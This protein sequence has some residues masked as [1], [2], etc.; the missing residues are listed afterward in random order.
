MKPSVMS[1][2]IAMIGTLGACATAPEKNASLEQARLAVD[3]VQSN[4]QVAQNAPVELARAR[5]ALREA[6][7]VW[8]NSPQDA[9]V[10][11]LAYLAERRAAIAQEIAGIKAA[12]QAIEQASRDRDRLL[13]Q[14]RTRE[15]E[16][17]REQL[18]TSE[19][20]VERA[21]RATQAA[22]EQAHVQEQLA[23]SA[24][25]RNARMQQRLQELQAQETER[26]FSVLLSG[27]LFESGEATLKAGADRRLEQL[28]AVLREN[29]DHVALVEGFT[30]STGD[31]TYNEDLSE[32]R[33]QAVREAL[34]S[35]GVDPGRIQVQGYGEAFP[36]ASN[37]TPA[38][39]QLNRRVE[40]IVASDS[41]NIPPRGFVGR[42]GGEPRGER[43]MRGS[44]SGQEQETPR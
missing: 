20:E 18:A 25:E 31:E 24:E 40:I 35:L 23:L 33:A 10:D 37:R 14:A 36:V 26:G 38:G 41:A 4:A 30:D 15:A 8:R 13:L 22:R 21:R 7:Q 5:E 16:Q 12:E 11:H 1:A 19:S 3:Q 28:A 34:A 42:A 27:V 39:R 6:E 29:P 44:G 9:R 32:Q 17:A 43:G 2:A